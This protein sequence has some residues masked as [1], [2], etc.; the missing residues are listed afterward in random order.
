[1]KALY[2]SMPTPLLAAWGK[3]GRDY[4]RMLDEVDNTRQYQQEFSRIDL[5]DPREG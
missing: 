1:M 3:Q 5:F 4:I 2:C